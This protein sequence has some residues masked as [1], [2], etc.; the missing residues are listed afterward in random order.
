[1]LLHWGGAAPLTHTNRTGEHHDLKGIG[2]SYEKIE[3]KG[4]VGKSKAFAG[5]EELRDIARTHHIKEEKT[6][7]KKAHC[8]SHAITEKGK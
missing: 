8:P 3:T 2:F 7:T 6:Q 1:L 4:N 5:K